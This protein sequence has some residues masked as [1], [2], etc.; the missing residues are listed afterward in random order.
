MDGRRRGEA[1]PHHAEIQILSRA[2]G[3]FLPGG[4]LRAGTWILHRIVSTCGEG[5]RHVRSNGR[6]QGGGRFA[7]RE[8]YRGV[9]Q[10]YENS[11]DHDR[12][13]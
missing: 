13:G 9:S 5:F 1:M 4:P 7:I 2:D 8:R 11:R 3:R 12:K 10:E 6:W